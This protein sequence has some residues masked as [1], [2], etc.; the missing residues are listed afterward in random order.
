MPMEASEYIELLIMARESVVYIAT[1][2]LTGFSAYLLA[3]Y[4]VGDNLTKAQ[5]IGLTFV[6]S[7]WSLYCTL[8]A[9]LQM[10]L[11]LEIAVGF[12][13]E[14]PEIAKTY[15]SAIRATGNKVYSLLVL[16]ICIPA[17]M[18]S[19]VYAYQRVFRNGI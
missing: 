12:F 7:A 6:Y 18:M 13:T 5:F 15:S 14:H 3:A 19:I 17:W 2:F 9:T 8:A 11:A 10:N 4:T 16:G 1:A